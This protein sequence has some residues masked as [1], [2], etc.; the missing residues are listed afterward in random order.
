MSTAIGDAFLRVRAQTGDFEKEA[1]SKIGGTLKRI[2]GAAAAAFAAVKVKDFFA[3]AISNASDLEE[4]MSKVRVVFED[5]AGAVEKFAANAPTALGQTR[6]QALEAAGT[7]GNLLT[8][9]GLAED[10]AADMSTTFVQLA[11]DLGSF[12]NVP[13]DE[14]LEALRSGLVGET[15]PL[16]RFGVNL[17][18]AR[19]EAKAL[20]LGL[21][22][23]K[24]ELDAAAKS[25]AAY[26]LILEDTEKAQG[27][28]A[29]TSG[30]LANQQKILSARFEDIKTRIGTALLPV[31]TR[32]V[33]L[34][35]DGMGPAFEFVSRV[36]RQVGEVFSTIASV[37][38]GS[39]DEA[40]GVGSR[41][42]GVAETISEFVNRLIE[43]VQ[44]I[45]PVVAPVVALVV[46]KFGEILA[47]VQAN[48]PVI[49]QIISDVI[50]IVSEVISKAVT[51]ITALWSVFGDDL[52]RIVNATFNTIKAVIEAVIKV[53]AGIVQFVLS[54]IKGDFSGAFEAIKSIVA[55]GLDL[56]KALF[57]NALDAVIGLLGAFFDGA[58]AVLGKVLD[59]VKSIPGRIL[60][61]LADLGSL[62]FN[63]G[64][65]LLT[66]LL[67]GLE[68]FIGL[69]INFF[70][71]L[72]GRFLDGLGNIGELLVNVGKDLIRGLIRGIKSLAGSAVDAVKG[73]LGSIVD[74]AMKLLGENSPSKVFHGIGENAM[75]G[76]RNGLRSGTASVD[77]IMTRIIEQITRR[78]Q[79]VGDLDPFTLAGLT[80]QLESAT[81]LIRQEI[82]VVEAKVDPII[83][84][85]LTA[86]AVGEAAT[87]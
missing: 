9:T 10:K 19:I 4:S 28:F 21:I 79:G 74:G 61:L 60:D 29:R 50:A 16:K 18:Q 30:G 63:K 59:F 57:R 87:R 69:V 2:A 62:L 73:V 67:N 23:N 38:R 36:G 31:A 22:S 40:E 24:G 35:S 76:L 71:G 27:D 20:E 70:K 47:V 1:E 8:A 84:A 66:G 64:R 55:A 54:I 51:V 45:I 75:V 17:N 34:L 85:Q 3:G 13:V 12:N 53:V 39:G 33:T 6:Q 43:T 56:V 41:I 52:L 83:T 32:L 25:Q 26:A 86:R 42:R 15:E 5:S 7:L 68:G 44:R 48:F 37:F 78:F 72:P 77:D 11:T 82:T 81:R 14:A 58:R 46:Q 80:G 65:D 49:Q